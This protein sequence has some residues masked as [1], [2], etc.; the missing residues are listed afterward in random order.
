MALD[1]DQALTPGERIRQQREAGLANLSYAADTLRW[2]A[3]N[4]LLPLRK[5]KQGF[6]TIT[7]RATGEVLF[8]P[9]A[10]RKWLRRRAEASQ[11]TLEGFG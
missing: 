7:D 5:G 2:M 4:N 1:S 10:R 6:V 3:R 11:L 9:S 8:P